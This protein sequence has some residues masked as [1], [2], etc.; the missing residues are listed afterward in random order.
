MTFNNTKIWFSIFLMNHCRF[1][2]LHSSL[3]E[4]KFCNKSIGL[5]QGFSCCT[6]NQKNAPIILR[7]NHLKKKTYCLNDSIL[8]VV[9]SKNV[10]SSFIY[11]LNEQ[12]HHHYWPL[13]NYQHYQT[14][15]NA[16]GCRI[17]VTCTKDIRLNK[18]LC[19]GN[20]FLCQVNKDFSVVS[21]KHTQQKKM[22]RC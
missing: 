22:T 14:L 17:H 1:C 21:G 20:L 11:F 5:R 6:H 13:R 2:L 7:T 19:L 12:S 15:Q 8:G 4:R 16:E 3:S 10:Y 18:G 9:F